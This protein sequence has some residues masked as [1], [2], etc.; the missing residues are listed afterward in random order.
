MKKP[1]PFVLAAVAATA[2]CLTPVFATRVTL[3]VPASAI[4]AYEGTFP[5]QV[6]VEL[7]HV[8]RD[9][10][11]ESIELHQVAVLCEGVEELSI[12]EQHAKSVG[13]AAATEARAAIIPLVLSQDD[14]VPPCGALEEAA[15]LS[16]GGTAQGLAVDDAAFGPTTAATIAD[17]AC[18]G[19][20]TIE[21]Q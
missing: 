21:L 17:G 9:T 7:K 20:A 4:E 6:V 5:A 12:R 11:E 16:S 10:G 14:E 1:V 13:C 3:D 15:F 2:A 18:G 19:D 8:D